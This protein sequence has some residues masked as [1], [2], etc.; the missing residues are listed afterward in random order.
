MSKQLVVKTKRTS[1][2]FVE[3]FTNFTTQNSERNR[4]IQDAEQMSNP[5]LTNKPGKS[6]DA[7]EM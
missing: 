7:L 5:E 4:T 6:S 2:C 3:I 1:L